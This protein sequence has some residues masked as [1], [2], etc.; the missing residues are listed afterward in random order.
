[1]IVVRTCAMLCKDAWENSLEGS[2]H[3]RFIASTLLGISA[4]LVHL[5]TQCT[6]QHVYSVQRVS[7]INCKIVIPACL[8]VILND[9][10]NFRLVRSQPSPESTQPNPQAPP[11]VADHKFSIP[12]A[13]HEI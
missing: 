9:L 5:R 2:D 11:N 10:Y 8:L 6:L 3:E 13:G 1:M 4:G 12:Q 7:S